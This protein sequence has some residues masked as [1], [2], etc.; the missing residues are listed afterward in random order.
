MTD[1]VIHT[2]CSPYKLILMKNECYHNMIAEYYENFMKTY[3]PLNLSVT[4]LVWSGVSFPA[5]DTY[6]FPEDM[7][8]I[9][10]CYLSY[11]SYQLII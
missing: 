4:Y 11:A 3:K 10:F 2:F 7:E 6:K 9:G 8:F 5:F 1:K